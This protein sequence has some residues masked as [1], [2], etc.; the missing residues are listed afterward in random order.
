MTL[1]SAGKNRESLAPCPRLEARRRSS[2]AR[3]TRTTSRPQA[4]SR[5]MRKGE[6]HGPKPDYAHER[7]EDRLA[8]SLAQIRVESRQREHRVQR[9][10][11]GKLEGRAVRDTAAGIVYLLCKHADVLCLVRCEIKEENAKSE[12]T[13]MMAMR[14]GI[15]GNVAMGVAEKGACPD[16]STAGM[17][18]QP[19][20]RIDI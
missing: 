3:G 8:A 9:A 7:C 14:R 5:K 1:I 6:S 19:T 2:G 10:T 20:L 16:K 18:P 4:T 17:R 13:M 12:W 15:C 11:E